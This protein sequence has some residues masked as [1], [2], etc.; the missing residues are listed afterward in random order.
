MK[1]VRPKSGLSS[2]SRVSGKEKPVSLKKRDTG[3]ST[4]CLVRKVTSSSPGSPSAVKTW[5]TPLA[6]SEP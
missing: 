5:M 4:P 3:K 1:F 2:S 6:A